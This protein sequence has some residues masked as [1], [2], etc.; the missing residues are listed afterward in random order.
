MARLMADKTVWDRPRLADPHGQPDKADR[1]RTMFDAIAP[2]Y[3]RVNRVTS[4][5][6]DAYWRKTAV[7]L[8]HIRPTDRV[9]D[10]ACGTGDFARAFAEASPAVVIGSDFAARMLALAASRGNGGIKWCR[11]DGLALP[12]ESGAFTVVSCAFGVRNFQDLGDG[13]REFHRVLVPGGRAVIL[14]FSMPRS[15]LLRLIYSV[16][17]RRVLPWLATRISRDRTGAYRY[18]PQSVSS[19]VDNRGMA[20]ALK[21]AGFVSVEHRGLTAGIVTVHLARKA[22]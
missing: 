14:E 9:L 20:A 11:A 5:G 8:A 4:V 12:F 17:F 16:Y 13:L 1:V 6:R 7:A 22:P 3:E 21:D 2:T 10:V 15:R 19:F 18:L